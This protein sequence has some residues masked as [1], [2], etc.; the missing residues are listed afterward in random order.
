MTGRGQTGTV[1]DIREPNND[2]S[3]GVDGE[4]VAKEPVSQGEGMAGWLDSLLQ[5]DIGSHQRPLDQIEVEVTVVVVVEKSAP[6]AHVLGH[7]EA[8]G[9]AVEMDEVEPDRG[10]DVGE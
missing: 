9:H 6:G 1:G 7:I 3:L 8:A 10:G 5:T 2:L 4:I